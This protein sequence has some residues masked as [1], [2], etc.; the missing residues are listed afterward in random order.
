MGFLLSLAVIVVVL[1][2]LMAVQ[3]FIS[4]VQK[5]ARIRSRSAA[6]S[7]LERQAR[8][9]GWRWVPDDEDVPAGRMSA[10]ERTRHSAVA[11]THAGRTVRIAVFSSSMPDST[12]QGVTISRAVLPGLVVAV[13]TPE[14][15]GSL[16][17]N[18]MQGAQRYG[19]LG[20]LA[21]LV[22]GDTE[23]KVF[24]RLRSCGPPAVDVGDGVACFT[25]TDMDLADQ[26]DEL[27]ALACDV[28]ELLVDVRKATSLGED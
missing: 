20:S 1:L 11:G 21:P 17:F 23:R 24:A 14:L 26:P 12:W 8:K 25:F 16:Q 4:V 7:A 22:P 9:P 10:A 6:G 28:V 5:N 2:I 15:L 19:V 18:P 3:S 27:V 13:D